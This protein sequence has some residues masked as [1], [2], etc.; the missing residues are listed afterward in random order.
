MV[1]SLKRHKPLALKELPMA[2]VIEMIYNGSK[3]EESSFSHK[4]DGVEYAVGYAS[5]RGNKDAP[6]FKLPL[7]E[8]HLS[9]PVGSLLMV[10]VT[11]KQAF[12]SGSAL[13]LPEGGFTVLE[14]KPAISKAPVDLSE[15]L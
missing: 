15:Y 3:N 11:T 2:K 10:E 7:A 13:F 5:I 6:S 9:L 14:V 12:P 4:H 1:L 8:E